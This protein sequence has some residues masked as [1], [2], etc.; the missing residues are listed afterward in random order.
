MANQYG[1]IKTVAS[2][3]NI[4]TDK[5]CDDF[6]ASVTIFRGGNYVGNQWP[7][8]FLSNRNTVGSKKCRE[9][10]S[11]GIPPPTLM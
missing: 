5:N 11:D 1:I 10:E 6:R 7:F 9:L 8:I 2:G 4:K 3:S